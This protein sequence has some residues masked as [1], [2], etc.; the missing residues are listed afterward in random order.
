LSTPSILNVSV[1]TVMG[2]NDKASNG[3]TLPIHGLP[4][5]ALYLEA[6]QYLTVPLP[7]GHFRCVC[8]TDDILAD[9]DGNAVAEF[10]PALNEVPAL[11]AVVEAGRPFIPARFKESPTLGYDGARGVGEYQVEEI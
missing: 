8:L 10:T 4:P 6:G 5:F 3:Y 7:S 9:V 1:V 2:E 11:D